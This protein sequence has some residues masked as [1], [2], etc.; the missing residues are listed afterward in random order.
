MKR[1]GSACLLA[2]VLSQ[3]AMAQTAGDDRWMPRCPAEGTMAVIAAMNERATW[4]ASRE[5]FGAMPPATA[6]ATG[7]V[8][9]R[10]QL[11]CLMRDS[12]ATYPPAMAMAGGIVPSTMQASLSREAFDALR[13]LLPVAAGRSATYDRKFVD[14]GGTE[15]MHWRGTVAFD[16][17]VPL[18]IAGA[19]YRAARLRVI[20]E[21]IWGADATERTYHYDV[22]TGVLLREEFVARRGAPARTPDWQVTM[23]S[24]PPPPAPPS[25]SVTAIGRM[26]NNRP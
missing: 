18:T 13:P 22:A 14:G 8:D 1:L 7:Q 10:S 3:G 12:A 11:S 20:E 17:Y 6:P 5:F 2:C 23:L 15:Q 9:P 24:V 19:Q 16:G 21:Q 4:R 25:R 26:R